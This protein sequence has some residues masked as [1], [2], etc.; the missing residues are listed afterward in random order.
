MQMGL[1]SF[2]YCIYTIKVSF[3]FLRVNSGAVSSP[4]SQHGYN[5]VLDYC[6][7]SWLLET[8]MAKGQQAV[9]FTELISSGVV[10][11]N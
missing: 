9:N 4:H 3:A 5:H 10:K 6:M 7:N 1:F 2:L 8:Q 11:L